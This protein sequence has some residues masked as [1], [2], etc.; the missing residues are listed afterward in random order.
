M[1]AKT[2]RR[3]LL[4]ALLFVVSNN[5][6]SQTV[7]MA[8]PTGSGTFGNSITLLINGN[9]IITDPLYSEAGVS[10]IGAVYLYNGSTNNLISTLKG[11]SA[12]D[13][14]GSAIFVLTNGNFLVGSPSWHNGPLQGAGAL[15]WCNGTTGL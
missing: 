7:D 4:A 10:H 11:S 2:L 5:V 9:Y 8:G 3:T 12:N 6:N 15:T 1:F 14:I 13:Q